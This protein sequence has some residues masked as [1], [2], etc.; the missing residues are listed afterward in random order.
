MTKNNS[1]YYSKSKRFAWFLGVA[2][3]LLT[4]YGFYKNIE[5]AAVVFASGIGSAVALYS[6]KQYQNR[7][8]L[9]IQ[10]EES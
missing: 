9:E 6:N 7:K 2:T 5:G 10:K 4:F 1:Y 3:V 8:I